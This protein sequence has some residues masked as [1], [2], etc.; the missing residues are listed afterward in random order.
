MIRYLNYNDKS[1]LLQRFCTKQELPL[2]GTNPLLFTDYLIELLKKRK[3][4]RKIC[5]IL[6]QKQ[7][8]FM[9]AYLATLLITLTNGEQSTFLNPQ[10]AELFMEGNEEHDEQPQTIPQT[11]TPAKAPRLNRQNYY[12]P[13]RQK[14]KYS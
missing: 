11:Q 10:E 7:I 4:F 9:L 6:H 12:T 14:Q 13:K 8:R 5:T 1:T 3:S 2:Q